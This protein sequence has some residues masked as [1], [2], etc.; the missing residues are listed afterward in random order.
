MIL[1]R[2]VTWTSQVLFELVA[3]KNWST[4]GSEN[5]LLGGSGTSRT[6]VTGKSMHSFQP[7]SKPAVPFARLRCTLLLLVFNFCIC[8]FSWW[9]KNTYRV[10]SANFSRRKIGHAH[11]NSRDSEDVAGASEPSVHAHFIFLFEN[12][13]G[14]QSFFYPWPKYS[15]NE[16]TTRSA[17]GRLTRHRQ[18]VSVRPPAAL[19]KVLFSI[20]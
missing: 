5:L 1:R 6:R 13:Q 7:C 12:G 17:D 16:S 20:A 3:K 11:D 18:G 4:I 8:T 9:S 14:N 15:W 2:T 10:V 19:R